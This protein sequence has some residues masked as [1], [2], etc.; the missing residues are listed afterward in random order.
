MSLPPHATQKPPSDFT[1]VDIALLQ[2]TKELRDVAGR[3]S[4]GD[5]A[6]RVPTSFAFGTV[7]WLDMLAHITPS[8]ALLFIRAGETE[9][10]LGYPAKEVW[11]M[12]SSAIDIL[13]QHGKQIDRLEGGKWDRSPS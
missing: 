4:P 1:D 6:R 2:R 5:P 12:E 13:D 11:S 10:Y 3:L 7:A 8:K 9:S